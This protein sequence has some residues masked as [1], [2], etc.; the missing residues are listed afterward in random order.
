MLGK[1]IDGMIS[2]ADTFLS[3]S[4]TDIA[5]YVDLETVDDDLERGPR[6]ET[7]QV[8]GQDN[9]TATLLVGKDG[10]L[11]SIVEIQGLRS[12]IDGHGIFGDIVMP[13]TTALQTAM[14]TKAHQIQVF[15]EEDYDDVR[16]IIDQAHA[17]TREAAVDRQMDVLDL[18]DA[19]AKNLSRQISLQRCY[20]ACW[21][22]PAAL[23]KDDSKLEAKTSAEAR[24]GVPYSPN[25]Q[26][27]LRAVGMLRNRH[28]AFMGTI[29]NTLAK[30]GVVADV[31]GAREALREVRRSIAPA[32]TSDSWTP[33]LPGDR[34]YP[35]VR[36]KSV[37]K[38]SWEVLWPPLGWQLCPNDAT[39]VAANR[40]QMGDRVYSPIYIDMF[41]RQPQFFDALFYD[42]RSKRVPWR[43]SY[44]MEGGGFDGLAFRRLISQLMGFANRGNQMFK[45][46]YNDLQAFAEQSGAVI[47]ARVALAT[48]APV[49]QDELLAKRASD[50]ARSVEGWGS[51]GVSEVTG[52]PIAGVMSSSLGATLGSIGTKAIAPMSDF[53]AMMPWDMPASAWKAG[54]VLFRSPSGKLMP[55]QPYSTLQTTWINIIFAPPGAGKS[56]LMNALHFALTLK[57][58]SKRLPRIAITDIGR[59][60]EGLISLV[61]E[62][63]PPELRHLAVHRRLR[64]SVEDAINPFDAPVGARFPPGIQIQFLNNLLL[65]L[66]TDPSETVAEKGMAGLTKRVV[67]EMYTLRSDTNEPNLYA[68]GLLPEVDRVVMSERIPI[69]RHTTWFEIVDK[70]FVAGHHVAATLAQRYA[71]PLL[72]DAITAATSERIRDSYGEVKTSTGENLIN[73]FTR[74]ISEA[75]DYFPTLSRPT[76]FDLGNAR[77][78]ALDLDAVAKKGSA[79]ADRM[80]AV[81]YMLARQVMTKDFYLHPDDVKELPAPP[82]FELRESVPVQAYQEYYLQRASETL[83]DA[84][85]VCYDEFHRTSKSEAVREQVVVDMREG[86]KYK[87][88]VMLASQSIEDFDERMME[89]VTS[90]FILDGGVGEASD[91]IARR[92]G[93]E[94]EAERW[95]LKN[96]VRPPKGGQ[97]GV[98]MAK[99]RTNLSSRPYT[100]LLSLPLSPQEFWA[101]NTDADNVVLRT[102]LYKSLGP[103]KARRVLAKLYP[104]GALREIDNRRNASGNRHKGNDEGVIEQLA[105]EIEQRA[106]M[107]E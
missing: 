71:S 8:I 96:S 4:K 105:L 23:N 99:F 34:M 76:A 2:I 15:F 56:V 18:L 68:A 86:R 83:E 88:D 78:V 61:Q 31:L 67:Q 7:G 73:A 91:A 50:L 21:T 69:D 28:K 51:C 98:F 100:T 63:L 75:L 77:I 43:I 33:A 57:P 5:D 39:I 40:V 92:F 95:H 74:M 97:P 90:L 37:A 48:W 93:I 17:S 80:T 85:R 27:P 47:Q 29:S 46:A 52:D 103:A 11:M 35:S 59:S 36:K 26:D 62:A 79:V 65:L 45:Y 60:S 58:G 42:L 16:R 53:L 1:M 82:E 49:G 22:R 64:S 72:A 41:P 87:V 24:K 81:Y 19:S 44:L 10:S 9:D 12:V 32:Q 89:F 25:A 13:M 84:K 94:N 30:V 107:M 3:R 101:L 55:Y 20:L 66:A 14:E 38:E 6:S 102:R 106:M 70:L 104:G 54:S